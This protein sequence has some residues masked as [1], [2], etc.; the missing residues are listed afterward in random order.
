[1]YGKN[2]A[3]KHSLL[4]RGAAGRG[5]RRGLILALIVC[6]CSI[7]SVASLAYL[8]TSTSPVE[9]TFEKTHVA[10]EVVETFDGTVKSDVQIQNTGS[11]QSYI[12]AAVVVTW[13]PAG[14]D[15]A[16]ASGSVT[17]RKPV[18]GTDYTIEYAAADSGWVKGTDGYWYYTV[19]VDPNNS[20]QTL[21]ESC[22]LAQGAAP[23]AG[24]RLSVE[25]VASAIQSTPV[26]AVLD[27]WSSGVE[28]VS[29]TTL[30]IKQ[31][32]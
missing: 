21:I 1:M 27:S 18:A 17:A 25:I 23:P 26:E 20:T 6:L 32:G 30:N 8:F 15:S 16:A 31:G 12:R 13:V 24:Y 19:P 9:N 11:V 7:L 4:Q 5:K 2:K 22:R 3:D 29:G 14:E 10:C 28:S